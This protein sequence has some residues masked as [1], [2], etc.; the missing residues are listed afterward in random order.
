MRGKPARDRPKAVP[1]EPV[2]GV[3]G[4]LEAYCSEEEIS[5]RQETRQLDRFELALTSTLR[6]PEP[7]PKLCVKKY[8]RS[9]ADKVY[10]PEETRTFGACERSMDHLIDCVVECDLRKN[11][12]PPF[13]E[14]CSECS[15]I[16]V[17]SFF[18]DRTR[19]IRVDL[20]VQQPHSMR[21]KVY[22]QVH[23]QCLRFELLSMY[24]LRRADITRSQYDD[25]LGLKSCSQTMEPLLH[26]YSLFPP[27]QATDHCAAVYRYVLLLQIGTPHCFSF[28][29]RWSKEVLSDPLVKWALSAAGAFYSED[30]ARFLRMYQQADFLSAVIM[31]RLADFA[32]YRILCSILRSVVINTKETLWTVS[33]LQRC[34]WIVDPDFCTEFLEY[35][36]L[37]VEGDKVRFPR[38]TGPGQWDLNEWEEVLNLETVKHFR[39]RIG[40]GM[41]MLD[42]WQGFPRNQ[43]H[44]LRMK[45]KECNFSRVEIIRG[46]CDPVTPYPEE[47]TERPSSAISSFH[48]DVQSHPSGSPRSVALEALSPSP[49]VKSP[50]AWPQVA[51]PPVEPAT[52]QSAHQRQNFQATPTASIPVTPQFYPV[53]PCA[54]ATSTTA[55]AFPTSVPTPI[56]LSVPIES[57]L[58]DVVSL[59]PQLDDPVRERRREE[60]RLR[61]ADYFR[62]GRVF[63]AWVDVHRTEKKWRQ[64]PI[65]HHAMPP[66]RRVPLPLVHRQKAVEPK[67]KVKIREIPLPKGTL[68]ADQ[69][70][71]KRIVLQT[72]SGPRARDFALTVERFFRAD[73]NCAEIPDIPGSLVLCRNKSFRRYSSAVSLASAHCAESISKTLGFVNLA[74]VIMG[75][76]VPVQTR[77]DASER[78]DEAET[79]RLVALRADEYHVLFYLD[80]KRVHTV[81][82]VETTRLAVENAFTNSL[83]TAVKATCVGTILNGVMRFDSSS[84]DHALAKS[85]AETAV[86]I[87]REVKVADWAFNVFFEQ[88]Y[89]DQHDNEGAFAPRSRRTG[90]C[91]PY[92]PYSESWVQRCWDATWEHIREAQE[93][94][95]VRHAP[96]EWYREPFKHCSPKVIPKPR[97]ETSP[98][99]YWTGL[100]R[101]LHA[102]IPTTIMLPVRAICRPADLQRVDTVAT[103]TERRRRRRATYGG[104]A[105]SS[106]GDFSD[107]MSDSVSMCASADFAQRHREQS[108]W[109]RERIA[110]RM[111]KYENVLALI[112]SQSTP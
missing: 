102:D 38:R 29:S 46:E 53:T 41:K 11:I 5:L 3:R 28:T 55:P 90:L 89:D 26:A 87:L 31:A 95:S 79:A 101:D 74:L 106:A 8:Q 43:D 105:T 73:A 24:L 88:F 64:L 23:E 21:S 92:W 2:F 86:D 68:L 82:E 6:D 30:Y 108:T 35:H 69:D 22:F 85:R 65:A 63:F 33:Q 66:P 51:T 110:K 80:A 39:D 37:W 77:S 54:P 72:T 4:T 13:A 56:P 7:N 71:Y 16:D 91:I 111:K 100:R 32:R 40:N 109:E 44:L 97:F 15:F 107:F 94:V 99:E 78:L 76:A 112:N 52:F 61:R 98:M 70:L 10:L 47:R 36:G 9:A 103:R 67:E 12:T 17:Y 60:G 1:D 49:P 18:R 81:E 19:A 20:H 34:L 93:I 45:F 57:P 27:L 59:L 62:V 50:F 84:V 96:P 25:S 83:G 104:D 42:A 58:S 48:I 75:N 14:I